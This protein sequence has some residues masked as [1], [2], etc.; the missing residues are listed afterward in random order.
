MVI[1]CVFGCHNKPSK[2]SSISFH[3]VPRIRCKHGEETKMISTDRRRRWFNAIKRKDLDTTKDHVVCSDHFVSGKPAALY[4]RSSVDWVPSL[5]MGYNNDVNTTQRSLAAASRDE[6]RKDRKRKLED[7][8]EQVVPTASSSSSLSSNEN[9]PITNII[10]DFEI[11]AATTSDHVPV[12][13]NTSST[14]VQ[15]DMKMKDLS[16]LED[17]VNGLASQLCKLRL[18]VNL[19]AVGVKEWYDDKDDKVLFYTGLPNIY[20]LETMFDFISCGVKHSARS[21]LTQFQEFSLTLIRF[22][23]NLTIQDLAYR[24]NISTSTTSSVILKWIDL[25]YIRLNPLIKWPSREDL[26]KTTPMSF[27]Q[28]FKTSVVVIIDCFEIFCNQPKNL[29]ARAETFSSYKH[30]NTIKILIG[31]TPQGVISFVSKAWGGRTPDKYLTDNC[32]ILENLLPQDVVLADRG[33]DI[34]ESTALFGATVEIPAFTKG[35]KQLSA[36]DVERSRKL[37]SVRVHVERVIGLLRNKY[38]ILQGILP[39]DYMMRVDEHN[40]STIDKIIV[41]CSA[42]TNIC[43][44]VIPVD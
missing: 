9:Q 44:S 18:E 7:S 17:S 35:K 15:T 36:F 39:L 11:S 31:I 8:F 20:I 30:H 16:S 19:S 21:S 22:R 1:C 12:N 14:F 32:G 40:M 27:R 23:L 25:M 38:T 41:V 6:R 13:C 4:E 10:V 2:M 24:F 5:Y 34:G 3:D 28:H 42:L 26:I 29:L 43:D 37:A 33:F